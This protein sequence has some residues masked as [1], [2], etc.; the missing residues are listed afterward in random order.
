MTSASNQLAVVDIP[1]SCGNAPRKVVICDLVVA[2]AERRTEDVLA[3]LSDD[4]R[5]D[6]LGS[7]ALAGENAVR[8]WFATAPEASELHLHTVATHGTECAVD[9]VLVTTTGQ[10]LAFAHLLRFSGHSKTAVVK[11]LRSYLIAD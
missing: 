10:R 6:V 5:W 8:D 4:I 2:W 9:G 1:E 7:E 11:Q 3:Y